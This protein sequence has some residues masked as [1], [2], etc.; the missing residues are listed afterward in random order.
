MPAG[1]CVIFF[2]AM[3]R[4]V[5]LRDFARRLSKSDKFFENLMIVR[6]IHE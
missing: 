1:N 2:A 6:R 4:E 5:L 3:K